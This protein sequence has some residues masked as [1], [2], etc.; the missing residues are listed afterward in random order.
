MSSILKHPLI[1][2]WLYLSFS[3]T[4]LFTPTV[5]HWLFYL[6]FLIIIIRVEKIN[7]VKVLKSLRSFIYFLPLM[8][9]FYLII[10]ML[11]SQSPILKI[12]IEIGTV[13]MRFI[14]VIAI[15]NVYTM[16]SVSGS[17]FQALRSTWVQFKKSWRKIE[18]WFLF[19][20]MTLRFYP[21]LQREWISWQSIHK[22][23][24]LNISQGRI[25]R[26]K[27]TAMQLPGMIMI[28]LQKADDISQAMILRGYGKNIPRGV[29]QPIHF[30]ILHF[31][32][33]VII[34]FLF[35]TLHNIAQV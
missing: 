23:L 17:V 7:F 2:L 29:A 25:S 3:T 9:G 19:M 21:S 14:L 32:A 12:F 6:L 1:R 31:S 30:S 18:D 16:G 35:F 34:T 27:E 5:I 28:Q 33:I 24:G 13:V 20:E 22:A 11:M 8:I 15:M 4:V 10:S 26:W